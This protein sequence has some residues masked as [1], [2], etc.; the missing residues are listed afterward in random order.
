VKYRLIIAAL[1]A[2]ITLA[3]CGSNIPTGS[4]SSADSFRS[5]GVAPV[6]YVLNTA[7]YQA[8][9]SVFSGPTTSFVRSVQLGKLS[10]QGGTIATDSEGH[11]YA[12][13]SSY[14]KQVLNVY[15]SKA[16]RVAYALEQEKLFSYVT[17]DSR[18]HI[19]TACSTTRICEYAAVGKNDRTQLVRS[20][21]LKA[22]G[23]VVGQWQW[24]AEAISP[25]AIQTLF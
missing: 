6:V 5:Q 22:L 23:A 20:I 24:T 13:P 8:T 11:F 14:G 9:I 12:S 18:N 21:G 1:A 17:L 10:D 15:T 4:I 3:A 7:D 2:S 25:S 19:Y 16:A